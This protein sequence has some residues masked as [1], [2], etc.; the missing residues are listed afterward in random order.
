MPNV[1]TMN[2]AEL[3]LG[4]CH[5]GTPPVGPGASNTFVGLFP[6]LRAGDSYAP[7]ECSDPH[8]RLCISGSPDVLIE[9]L[10]AFRTGDFIS[11]GD[12]GGIGLNNVFIN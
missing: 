5:P 9:G 8:P 12:V 10:P 1:L 11:C 2:P 6:V 3:S 7:A 4:H